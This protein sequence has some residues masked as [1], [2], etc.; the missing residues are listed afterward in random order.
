MSVSGTPG[1]RVLVMSSISLPRG[2]SALD[3]P[4]GV[5]T[6]H[7]HMAFLSAGLAAPAPL[8]AADPAFGI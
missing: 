2:T 3:R 1:D 7:T 4:G 5:C 8:Y 6:R